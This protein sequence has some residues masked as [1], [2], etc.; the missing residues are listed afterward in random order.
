M[1]HLS[2]IHNIYFT[3]EISF[4]R[5][6]SICTVQID[7]M[8]FKD[9]FF[10]RAQTCFSLKQLEVTFNNVH[11]IVLTAHIKC[12]YGANFRYTVCY[13]YIPLLNTHLNYTLTSIQQIV[14]Y[15]IH[16]IILRCCILRRWLFVKVNVQWWKLQWFV[17]RF[18]I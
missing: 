5:N 2:S 3:I 13:V 18:I 17:Y 16:N 7:I 8:Q 1:V 15:I 10:L 4:C 9:I 12:A 11:Y 6:A 14:R